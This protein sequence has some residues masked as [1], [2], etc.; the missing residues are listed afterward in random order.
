M[1]TWKASRFACVSLCFAP[2]SC[3]LAFVF[4]FQRVLQREIRLL[5]KL[6]HPNIVK[7]IETVREHNYLNIVLE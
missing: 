3:C 1:L 5:E 7:Y 6:S 2:V 4:S